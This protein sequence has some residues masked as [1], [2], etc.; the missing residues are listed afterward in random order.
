MY[1]E[2]IESKSFNKKLKKEVKRLGVNPSMEGVIR[3]Y[4][5]IKTY[6]E[7][8]QDIRINLNEEKNGTNGGLYMHYCKKIIFYEK[9][10]LI[11]V[12]HELRHYIQFNT[13]L[14]FLLNSYSK[15]EED[16][17]AWSSSL[18]FSVF[19]KEYKELAKTGKIKF[20]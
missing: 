7:I 5:F 19:P 1:Y 18:F 9:L 12:L 3:F 8:D 2:M 14:I 20:I 10:S 11:T 6:N 16:A 15:R 4:N 13:D 17:R